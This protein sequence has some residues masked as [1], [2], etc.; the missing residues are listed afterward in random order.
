MT[1][2]LSLSAAAAALI[3]TACSG[4]GAP[5]PGTGTGSPATPPATRTLRPLDLVGVWMQ[6]EDPERLGWLVRFTSGTRF[7]M[8]DGGQ[9]LTAP[10]ARGTYDLD[11]GVMT[12]SNQGA[13][14]CGEGD[15]WSWR[16]TL[17]EGGRLQ[18]VHLDEATGPCR[19]PTQTRW[20][21]V[22]VS[23]GQPPGH[24]FVTASA[25]DDGP[26]PSAS[27]LA[28]VWLEV[29]QPGGGLVIVL[30]PDGSF[31][32][33]DGGYLDTDPTLSTEAP[34]VVGRYRLRGDRLTF[35]TTGGHACDGGT[36]FA[37]RV[38]EPE[39]GLLH[40]EHVKEGLQNC[41]VPKGTVWTLLRASPLGA[42]GARLLATALDGSV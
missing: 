22:R 3:L 5:G 35:T 8:D 11:D 14:R 15:R 1:R 27:D 21:L 31:V 17:V 4:G 2:T 13:A 10:D 42:G 39:D 34:S 29:Q 20:T 30:G 38:S 6:V 40:V 41:R 16:A 24:E 28:G 33:D 26:P 37:W 19:I 9:L 12:F 23:P 25:P 18:V 32:I 7:A 36:A